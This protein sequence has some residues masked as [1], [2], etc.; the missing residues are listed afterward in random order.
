MTVA[1]AAACLECAPE[2]VRRAIRGGKLACYRLG[3]CIRISADQLG[4]YLEASLCPAREQNSPAAAMDD[5]DQT[6][7]VDVFRHQQRVRRALEPRPT[8]Q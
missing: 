5:H 6:S 1:D 3:G 8:K 7:A 2:T 4:A